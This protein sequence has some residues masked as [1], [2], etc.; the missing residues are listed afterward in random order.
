VLEDAYLVRDPHTDDESIQVV[1]RDVTQQRRTELAL[2]ASERRF[3]ETLEGIQ[4]AA[5]QL[6]P[7]MRIIFCNNA[8]L[9]LTGWERDEILGRDWMEV[10]VPLDWHDRLLQDFPLDELNGAALE[11]HYENPILT[12]DGE[13]RFLIWNN[14]QLL[15][16]NNRL[17]GVTCIGQD[18]T[19]R[20]MAE[21][22]MIE[23]ETKYRTLVEMFPFSV[24][25]FVDDL[26]VFVNETTLHTLRLQSDVQILGT[27][28]LR[29]VAARERDRMTRYT[30]MRKDF[31]ADAPLQYESVFQ[32]A[33]GEEFPTEVHV[34]EVTFRGQFA[35]QFLVIDITERQR[36]QQAVRESERKYRDILES[37]QEG[38]YEIS[39]EGLF[40]F[41]NPALCRMLGYTPDE[42]LGL[43]YTRLYNSDEGRQ[44]A[45]EAYAHVYRTGV[46]LQ[47]LDWSLVRKDGASA[48]F[49][50]S[51]GPMRVSGDSGASNGASGSISGFRG[52]VR[53]VS[54]R[55][56]A[57]SALREAEGRYRELFENAND[58]VYTHDL[59]G[60]FT[61]LNKAGEEIS[62][63]TRDEAMELHVN[64]VLATQY[65]SLASDMF[66]RKLNES[67]IT[68]YEAEIIN[69]S[70]A[71]IPVE[72]STRLIY[73][74]G[75]PVGVQG[76]ARDIT[77]R[78]QAEEERQRLEAQIQHSQKLEGLGVLAGGIAHDFNNLL[79]GILGNAGLAMSRMQ[80]ND[81]AR[82]F[83]R[84]VEDTA[85]RAAELTNQMLAYAGKGTF[86]KRP[87]NLSNLAREMGQLLAASISKNV[88]LQYDCDPAIPMV[89]GDSAQIHQVILNLVTNASDAV[90][91][92]PG[93]I[94][95][96][97][98]TAN[99]GTDF[100][101]E[102][103][104]NEEVA[105]GRYVCL[106]VTD[107]GCGMP[108][109]TQAR[110][111]DPFFST[112]F[113][114]RGLG[115]AAALGI[116][117]SHGGA[118]SVRST[119]GKGT[120]F[121]VYLP[122]CGSTATSHAINQPV[123]T[124]PFRTWRTTGLVLIVDDEETVRAVAEETLHEVG[125][126][127]RT[128]NDG[129]EAV[130]IFS[131][132]PQSFTAVLMDL[133]MPAMNG[134][135]AIEELKRIRPDVPVILS[136]GYTAEDA[137]GSVRKHARTAF[138][139]KPYAPTQLLKLLQSLL[140]DA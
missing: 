88:A 29:F 97:T 123:D 130:A 13:R 98:F 102:A 134:N 129:A 132:Q 114:G 75:A 5:V 86:V 52:I 36:A 133:M 17:M 109:E 92:K 24:L 105:P 40:T 6:D 14:T 37:I 78:R 22:A 112:K 54:D 28:A 62:G 139:Q 103:Y 38:Y 25:I 89:E 53:D 121:R 108:P 55:K 74:D 100:K 70:G 136:S 3:R 59:E 64:D 72:I 94:I 73:K 41:F 77:E 125:F 35:L 99:I 27:D 44:R 58:I 39:T 7:K 137:G 71:R 126:E 61:A 26:V 101:S 87:L 93:T 42:M 104:L 32:R 120:T 96:R 67:A 117:R 115:L 127:T 10:F 69:K 30:E 81:A 113:T 45:Y 2:Q 119:P 18:I 46:D 50:I 85:Q 118:V 23:S 19:E 90:G 47:L 106:E 135:Q 15:D 82:G 16:E 131:E 11:R 111:F 20:R 21:E 84:K 43:S 83:V 128:A 68:R 65:S 138:I 12:R 80:P 63:Y 57:E 91:D 9:E 8:L 140:A 122:V 56:Q 76:I 116:V 4:L 33:D 34:R 49:E 124:D 95:L 51:I 31:D 48:F 110:I 66:E 60:R 1:M 107:T 79:V